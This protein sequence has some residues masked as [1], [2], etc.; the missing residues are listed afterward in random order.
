MSFTPPASNGGAPI[1]VVHGD[2]VARAARSAS[3][4]S[5]PIVVPGLTNGIALHV[6]RDGDERGRDER[7]LGAVERR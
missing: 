5:S 1:G 2:G 4:T 3:G 7:R 6:H